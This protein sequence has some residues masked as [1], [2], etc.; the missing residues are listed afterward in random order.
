MK[1]RYLKS[2][3]F[4]QCTDT[5]QKR[6]GGLF[7]TIMASILLLTGFSSST[8]YA[9]N[10]GFTITEDFKSSNADGIT[11]G[12]D[13][14]SAYLTS[15]VTNLA[16]K[17][18]DP[19]EEG[20]LR[21]TNATKQQAGYAVINESFPT[22]LGFLLDLEFVTW[23]GDGA[24][25]FSFFLFD[26]QYAP[27]TGTSPFRIG[28]PGDGLGYAHRLGT[29]GVSGGYLGVGVDEFG[30]YGTTEARKNGG[31]DGTGDRKP[32]SIAIRGPEKPLRSES[33]VFLGGTENIPAKLGIPNF[34]LDYKTPT[35]VRPDEELYYRRI[36][37]EFTPTDENGFIQYKVSTRIQ[38]EKDGPFRFIMDE[39]LVNDPPPANLNL[40]FAASTGANTHIHEIRNVM[41][42]TPQGVRVFKKVDKRRAYVGEELEYRIGLFN[43]SDI[44][45]QNLKFSDLI[46]DGFEP[47]SVVFNNHGNPLNTATGYTQTD[48]SDVTVG[49]DAYGEAE[50]VVKGNITGADP[51]GFLRNT[52]NFNANG[53]VYDP[54]TTNDISTAK[55]EVFDPKLL[56]EKSGTFI[57][58]NNDNRVNVGDVIDYTFNVTNTGNR[59]LSNIIITDPL[60]AVNGGPIDLEVGESDSITFTGTYAITQEDID[61]GGVYNQATATGKDRLN[62]ELTQTSVDPNPLDPTDPNYDPRRPD[63]TFVSLILNNIVITNPNI[64]QKVKGN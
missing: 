11:L 60:M 45:V 40:G 24:D 23:G 22:D 4:L 56:I 33:Y 31:F 7:L 14:Y 57:D 46:A 35:Q 17:V 26:A 36:I 34:K 55:T 19:E 37:L 6:M 54:N 9:Q 44:A 59:K 12:G 52:A 20:W 8:A 39:I 5:P 53:Q 38:T 21:L 64:Y 27:T 47:T 42:T 43:H 32:N 61:N 58:V 50:F 63:H 18:D 13:P 16:N 28:A 51:D 48:L 29:P 15:G 62:R 30:F 41:V 10:N 49:L 2:L 1:K 3:Y 25:G